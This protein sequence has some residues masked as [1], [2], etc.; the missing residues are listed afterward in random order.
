MAPKAQVPEVLLVTHSGD[1][2][3]IDLVT[4][5]LEQ[6][7]ARVLRLDTDLFPTSV[8]LGIELDLQGARPL[9]TLP[10][11]TVCDPARLV[12]VWVRKIFP[13]ALPKD[14]D[15][16]LAPGC[17]AECRGTLSGFWDALGHAR[18]LDP[19]QAMVAAEQKIRQLRL[20]AASGLLIPRTVVTNDP[21]AV[22]RLHAECG[23]RIVAKLL[24]ALST[25]MGQPSLFVH[26]S[27]V[28]DEDL[29]DL[30]N[31]SLS[32]MIFQERIDKS[33]ELRVAYVGGRCFAGAVDA[34]QTAGQ[35]DWR[36]AGVDECS[37]QPVELPGPE[38]EKLARLMDALELRFGA[39]DFIR[40]PE[41]KHVF[42]EV[43][44]A[45]EWGML[46]KNLGLPIAAAIAE[47]LLKS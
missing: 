3:N 18:L 33:V 6:R 14:L 2:F 40:T 5:E 38:Q 22:R 17:Q 23:G 36:L 28:S 26:T 44:P 15:P 19:P 16:S 32:P 43:N 7:G 45:G 47:E 34:A 39:V 1:F 20:A 10:D 24:N 30:D 27:A 11:G 31:L 29:E 8:R 25:S 4:E 42:L 37:W 13:A 9:L 12:G 41:G 46:E 35:V 21:L